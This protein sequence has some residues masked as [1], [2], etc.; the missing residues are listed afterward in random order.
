MVAA[1]LIYNKAIHR[2]IILDK[3]TI[4]SYG[5]S[6]LCFFVDIG[7]KKYVNSAFIYDLFEKAKT[8]NYYF[9]LHSIIFI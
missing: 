9:F 3:S 5:L 4:N 1:S 6:H 7:C 8:V 2:A